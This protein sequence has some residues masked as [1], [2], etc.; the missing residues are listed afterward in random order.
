MPDHLI[1][2]PI[3]ELLLWLVLAAVVLAVVLGFVQEAL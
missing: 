3:H 2:L 1:R